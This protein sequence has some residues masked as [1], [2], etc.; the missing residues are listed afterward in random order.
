MKARGKSITREKHDYAHNSIARWV[1]GEVLAQVQGMQ[2]PPGGNLC[3]CR[4]AVL[5]CGRRAITDRPYICAFA[6]ITHMVLLRSPSYWT[7]L[8]AT[9][10]TRQGR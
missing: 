10:L 9:S 2:H 1:K 8:L 3:A 4:A 7:R 5:G 6:Y